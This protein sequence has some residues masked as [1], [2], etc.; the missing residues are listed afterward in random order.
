M[1]AF[2][3]GLSAFFSMALP[4][5]AIVAIPL[6]LIL[7][8]FVRPSF[9]ACSLAGSAVVCLPL[10]GLFLFGLVTIKGEPDQSAFGHVS[11]LHGQPTIWWWLESAAIFGGAAAVGSA[12]GFVFWLI[13]AAGL[14]PAP[15]PERAG[16]PQH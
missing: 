2:V 15:A 10:L 9:W 3:I 11:V 7:R 8:R 5:T 4:W 6:F 12:S 14:K 16:E 1:W 13:A